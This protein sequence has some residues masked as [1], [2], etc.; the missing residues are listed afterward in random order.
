MVPE[1]P[2]PVSKPF[3]RRLP[4]ATTVLML[5]CVMWTVQIPWSGGSFQSSASLD[6]AGAIRP[7][8]LWDNEFERLATSIFLHGGWIHLLVNVVSLWFVGRVIEAGVGRGAYLLFLLGAAVGGVA[9]SLLWNMDPIW[10]VGISG[11]IAG[12]IGLVL[13]LEWGASRTWLEFLKSRNTIM[14]L[15]VLA[16]NVGISMYFKTIQGA[17]I[18][19]A[20]HLGGFL[21]G[22]IPGLAYFPRSRLR[23]ML[24]TAVL[25]L[26]VVPSIAYAARPFRYPG[27]Y[28][29]RAQQARVLGNADAEAEAWRQYLGLRPDDVRVRVR[30]AFLQ[31]D[32]ETL[33]GLQPERAA[34]ANMVAAAWLTLAGRRLEDD[35]ES[36]QQSMERAKAVANAVV[37]QAWMEFGQRAV[38][39][40]QQDLAT[41]A[42]REAYEASRLMGR[43]VAHWR[44]ALAM[45]ETLAREAGDPVEEEMLRRLLQLGRE[46][47]PGLGHLEGELHDRFERQL[48]NIGIVGIA[49]AR[50][51]EGEVER[52]L[53][54][55]LS[56]LFGAMAQQTPEDSPKIAELDLQMA[57]WW[58]V[59][60]EDKGGEETLEM[61]AG[62]FGTAWQ[63]AHRTK[64]E[65]VEKLARDWFERRGLP[66]PTPE[67]ADGEDDG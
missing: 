3:W 64:N 8:S 58:W 54:L 45:L 49:R 46:A 52:D 6:K 31:N 33:E 39:A 43:G 29:Y 66:V 10:R 60:A 27:Y 12:L 23:P 24:G 9:A 30:V 28:T 22:L 26:M 14:V 57:V 25:V 61:G 15:V 19:N 53:A 50:A 1:V 13:A 2:P 62:R 17:Q 18:D 21:C 48:V 7:S 38:A 56:E 59:A 5:L 34:E 20:G 55:A 11:G 4:P 67:L 37:P 42:F 44:P 32:P 36:A 41:F 47:A 40:E 16:I 63:S 51:A 35:P 65:R